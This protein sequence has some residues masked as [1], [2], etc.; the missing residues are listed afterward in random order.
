MLKD[1]NFHHIG[2]AVNSIEKA[3]LFYEKGGYVVSDTIIESNQKVKVAYANKEDQ[4]T[5]ELL[6]PLDDKS[7][8]NNILKKNG[9][10]P[11]H[12]CFE[13]ENLEEAVKEAKSLGYFPLSQPVPGHGLNDALMVFIYNKNVG[14]VQIMEKNP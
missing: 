13:V 9:C 12:L 10:T 1:S 5:I 3:R 11:Y 4:P 7:P 6:E 14:L 2:V 8:V